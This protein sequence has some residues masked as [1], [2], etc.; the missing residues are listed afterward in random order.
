MVF[1]SYLVV[2]TIIIYP[3]SFSLFSPKNFYQ[4]HSFYQVSP[5]V[6][7]SP[8][9]TTPHFSKDLSSPF[10]FLPLNK[11]HLHFLVLS[12]EFLSNTL[13]TPYYLLIPF[14][15][16]SISPHLALLFS[17]LPPI[18]YFLFSGLFIIVVIICYI[19]LFT[20]QKHTFKQVFHNNKAKA[21]KKPIPAPFYIR[22]T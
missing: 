16:L 1:Q 15:K 19:P 17:L 5:M 11:Q 2:D 3:L 6:S 12:K 18:F 4:I 22:G 13:V 14:N 10:T 20:P 8:T 21:F 7:L 9:L